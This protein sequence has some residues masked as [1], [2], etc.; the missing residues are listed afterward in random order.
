MKKP[1]KS[2]RR[3]WIR[4]PSGQDATYRPFGSAKDEAFVAR[5][6]DVSATGIGLL[7]NY[8][9]RAGTILTVCFESRGK[10]TRKVLVR[11][12]QC[13]AKSNG[14]WVIGCAMVTELSDQELAAL[15]A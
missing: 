8:S 5:V 11:V 12:R 3:I 14:S 13:N 2:E 6:L 4:Y 10:P 9:F 15:T 1:Q 7:A